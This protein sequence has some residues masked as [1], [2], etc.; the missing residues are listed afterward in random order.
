MHQ[1]LSTGEQLV[2][3][4]GKPQ[5]PAEDLAS[6]LPQSRP[7]SPA[8]RTPRQAKPPGQALADLYNGVDTPRRVPQLSI[9]SPTYNETTTPTY[10]LPVRTQVQRTLF[11]DLESDNNLPQRPDISPINRSSRNAHGWQDNSDQEEE[12]WLLVKNTSYDLTHL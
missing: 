9:R 2:I 5:A 3:F 8:P 10:H 6:I 12:V 4:D 11:H 7:T 1:P